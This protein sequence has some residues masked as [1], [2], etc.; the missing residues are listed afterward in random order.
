MDFFTNIMLEEEAKTKPS[1]N[2]FAS[3]LFDGVSS[4]PGVIRLSSGRP[5]MKT[6]ELQAN[7]W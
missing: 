7:C 3:S 2:I 1:V 5:I 4:D 6:K